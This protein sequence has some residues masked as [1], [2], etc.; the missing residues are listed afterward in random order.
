MLIEG[1]KVF[2]S[3]LLFLF[4][5]PSLYSPLFSSFFFFSTFCAFLSPRRR[6]AKAK[7]RFGTFVLLV[8]L[9]L[10]TIF[11]SIKR[12]GCFPLARL[13]PRARGQNPTEE[14]R[15]EEKKESERA[16]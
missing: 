9:F 8:K 3:P 11:V 16:R 13:R 5:S 12:Q 7:A 14:K 2:F 1:K 15:S 4:L 6:K 10:F